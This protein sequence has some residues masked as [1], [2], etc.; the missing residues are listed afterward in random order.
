MNELMDCHLISYYHRHYHVHPSVV[1][2]VIV[3]SEQRYQLNP[4]ARGNC[5]RSQHQHKEVSQ[6]RPTVSLVVQARGEVH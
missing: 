4:S 1:F 3:V 6:G 5:Q 2:V